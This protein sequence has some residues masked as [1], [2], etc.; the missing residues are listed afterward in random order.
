MCI[1][2]RARP[3]EPCSFAH[4]S[5]LSKKLLGLSFVFL[6]TNALTNE[7]LFTNFLKMSN[8][9]SSLSKIIVISEISKGFLKSGLSEHI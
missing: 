7:P 1:R 2:D 4:L 9:T 6:V 5:I 8:F 3:D